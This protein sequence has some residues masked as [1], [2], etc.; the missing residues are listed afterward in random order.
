[1]HVGRTKE[2]REG[3][4]GG[5]ERK[6]EKRVSLSQSTRLISPRLLRSVCLEGSRSGKVGCDDSSTVWEEGAL[7]FT[8]PKDKHT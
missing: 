1:M 4:E 3:G 2:E 5:R 8:E 7:Y 6:G